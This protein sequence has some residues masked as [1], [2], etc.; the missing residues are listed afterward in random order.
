MRAP[1][2]ILLCVFSSSAF[3]GD[4]QATFQET[5]NDVAR[6]DCERKDYPDLVIFDCQKELAL[7]Y[8]TKPGNPAHPGVVKRSVVQS[9]GAVSIRE[10]GQSY[11]SDDDQPAFKDWMGSI[12]ALDEK[13]KEDMARKTG[14]EPK[15]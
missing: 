15:Q 14:T 8:F 4:F 1:I 3:A 2:A 10:S 11:G 7:W 12:M 9:N 5:W 6:R 13:V